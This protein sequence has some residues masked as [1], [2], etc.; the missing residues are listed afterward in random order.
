MFDLSL[1]IGV[2]TLVDYGPFS[3]RTE[4][5][6]STGKFEITITVHVRRQIIWDTRAS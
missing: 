2:K 3:A 5:D 4:Y 1:S 6:T